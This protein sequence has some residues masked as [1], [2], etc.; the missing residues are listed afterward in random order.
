MENE[1]QSRGGGREQPLTPTLLP[2]DG[3]R[4]TAA[5]DGR[6]LLDELED[7]MRR[8]VVLPNFAAETLALWVL[9]TYAF[10][11]RD[12]STYLGIESP[13]K[14]CG[15]TTLLGVLSKLVHRP[16]AAVNISSPAFFRVIEEMGPTLLIDEADTF[17]NGNDELRGILNAGYSRETAFVVR[18]ANQV[19][20]AECRVRSAEPSPLTP[21]PSD[22]RG[23]AGPGLS[24]V[25]SAG[26]REA[27][28]MT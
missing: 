17:L 25:V 6:S 21:L 15:K 18:V 5:V 4:G 13:E 23:E 2:S 10:Q 16:V 14:R 11:L 24:R 27:T 26:W 7:V 1:D 9:H 12:V 19:Q 3:A 8:F 20:N 28:R 22:G